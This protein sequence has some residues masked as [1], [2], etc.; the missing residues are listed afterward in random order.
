MYSDSLYNMN[1]YLQNIGQNEAMHIIDTYFILNPAFITYNIDT[2][3][4]L[5][6]DYDYTYELMKDKIFTPVFKRMGHQKLYL[7]YG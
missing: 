3:F 6:T 1:I 5:L 7:I 4:T 2:F